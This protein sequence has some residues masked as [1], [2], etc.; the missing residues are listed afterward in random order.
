[1]GKRG[2]VELLISMEPYQILIADWIVFLILFL[3]V[4]GIGF[5]M[6]RAG[7]P[8]LIGPIILIPA[9][10][11]SALAIGEDVHRRW[12]GI[13]LMAPL[14][15]EPVRPRQRVRYGIA[16]ALWDSASAFR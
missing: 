1:M 11:L 7:V 12:N 6:L 13:S 8:E 9:N 14:N 10:W 2:L 3:G 16:R 15:V 4:V 5:L